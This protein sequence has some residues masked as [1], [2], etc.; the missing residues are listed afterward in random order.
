MAS[1]LIG[2]LPRCSSI[3]CP[4]SSAP[5]AGRA[6]AG[7]GADASIRH[8]KPGGRRRRP[9]ASPRGGRSRP[10]P[11]PLRAAV[12]GPP[13]LELDRDTSQATSS[14]PP[15]AGGR[16]ASLRFRGLRRRAR[17]QGAFAPG[18]LTPAGAAPAT[19]GPSMRDARP[20]PPHPRPTAPGR[21]RILEEVRRGPGCRRAVARAPRSSTRRGSGRCRGTA[22]PRPRSRYGRAWD[23]G[24]ATPWLLA[25]LLAVGG[26]PP[27]PFPREA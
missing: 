7:A 23:R 4:E 9:G 10:R 20:T 5:R 2:L 14:G 8:R 16:T 22:R 18:A 6:W 13:R 19:T 26:N 3:H 24:R 21:R 25:D 15:G 17:R 27:S 12:C 1:G 11:A